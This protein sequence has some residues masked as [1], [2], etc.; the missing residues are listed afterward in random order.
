MH[1][2]ASCAKR[3]AGRRLCR[4]LCMVAPHGAMD[5]SVKHWGY[6][7]L[8]ALDRMGTGQN[9]G[10]QTERGQSPFVAVGL[11][12][13]AVR[14]YCRFCCNCIACDKRGQSPFC[15]LSPSVSPSPILSCQCLR[16][17]SI[18]AQQRHSAQRAR[19]NTGGIAAST[20]LSC[21][22]LSSIPLLLLGLANMWSSLCLRAAPTCCQHVTAAAPVVTDMWAKHLL[23]R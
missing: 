4:P 13:S 23:A 2:S 15:P 12:A 17:A 3:G 22:Y 14:S 5:P 9:G 8:G 11:A 21:K 10:G 20:L 6:M 1:Q 19:P 7:G 18:A 16:L